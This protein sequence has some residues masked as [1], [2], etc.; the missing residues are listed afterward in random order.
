M[1]F[2]YI[3]V[4]IDCVIRYAEGNYKR[5]CPGKLHT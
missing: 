1:W 5:L 4:N 2:I 3:I